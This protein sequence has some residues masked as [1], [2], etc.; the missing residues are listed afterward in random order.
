VISEKVSEKKERRGLEKII[1]SRIIKRRGGEHVYATRRP[2]HFEG[3]V[4]APKRG[5]GGQKMK[6]RSLRRTASKGIGHGRPA[7]KSSPS[8]K[9][10]PGS[11]ARR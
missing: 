8:P 1:K 10:K 7:G 5:G 11:L 3:G 4:C 2:F 9:G 6:V